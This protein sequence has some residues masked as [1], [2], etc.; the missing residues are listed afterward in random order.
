MYWAH[1]AGETPSSA[2]VREMKEELGL[3]TKVSFKFKQLL[4]PITWSGFTEHELAYAFEAVSDTDLR[5]NI[6][7][8]DRVKFLSPSECVQLAIEHPDT[9]TPDAIILL[10]R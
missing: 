2:A 9:F 1:R 10:Q 8:I 4:L 3:E 5:I 7:E 6:E